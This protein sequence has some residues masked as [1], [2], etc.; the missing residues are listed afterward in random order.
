MMHFLQFLRN[1]RNI[2][3]HVFYSLSLLIVQLNAIPVSTKKQMVIII[4][5]LGTE[6]HILWQFFRKFIGEIRC[7][8][9]AY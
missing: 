6:I 5:H 2:E 8:H 3:W 9:L 4:T 1:I 7:F